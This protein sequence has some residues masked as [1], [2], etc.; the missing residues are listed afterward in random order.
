MRVGGD[1]ALDSRFLRRPETRIL[2]VLDKA[3][4]HASP[5]LESPKG[6]TWRFALPLSELR[7]SERL[8][9]LI[10]E[11]V[12]SRF[13]EDIELSKKPHRAGRDP[14]RTARDHTLLHALPLV[15]GDGT[16]NITLSIRK[17]YE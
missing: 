8:W 5:A 14:M 7:P 6:S 11:G 15:A 17:R 16:K 12:A 2:L 9:P 4:W 3:G 10:N 1:G 13:F